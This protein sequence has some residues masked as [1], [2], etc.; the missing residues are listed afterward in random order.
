MDTRRELHRLSTGPTHSHLVPRWLLFCVLAAIESK[1]FL[2]CA[3][4]DAMTVWLC[5]RQSGLPP[6][7]LSRMTGSPKG[8]ERLAQWADLSLTVVPEVRRAVVD[9]RLDQRAVVVPGIRARGAILSV[10]PAE[11]VQRDLLNK[12]GL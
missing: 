8:R 12:A 9:A 1:H 2:N 7:M 6:S 5:V 11:P 4:T 3:A 10:S